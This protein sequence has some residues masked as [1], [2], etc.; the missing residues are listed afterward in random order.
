MIS[1]ITLIINTIIICN[2]FIS[3]SISNYY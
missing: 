1:T 3:I 2:T